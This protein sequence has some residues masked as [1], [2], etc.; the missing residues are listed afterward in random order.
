VQFS[1]E[2]VRAAR[3]GRWQWCRFYRARAAAVKRL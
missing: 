1:R 3:S 2:G